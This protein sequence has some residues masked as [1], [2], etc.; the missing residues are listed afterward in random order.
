MKKEEKSQHAGLRR[1]ARRPE[2]GGMFL[3]A[4]SKCICALF[5]EIYYYLKQHY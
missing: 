4:L 1:R 3:F 2:T 5:R